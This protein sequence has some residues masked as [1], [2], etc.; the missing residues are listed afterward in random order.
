MPTINSITLRKAFYNFKH[1]Y[2]TMNN[3][4]VAVALMVAAGWAGGSITM[5]QR[6]FGLQK[7]LDARQR[8]LQLTELQ[9]ATL[10]YQQNYYKSDEYKE[11]MAREKLGLAA[12]GEKV[13]ILPPN[14]AQAKASDARPAPKLASTRSA[15]NFEQWMNF[16]T[17]KS[18][19][20]LQK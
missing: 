8:E 9:V 15:S 16:L 12:P 20:D 19:R 13:L 4:V 18:A 5:M 17:G 7:E 2:A 3:I 10:Q 6:N 1:R 11:L 14:S